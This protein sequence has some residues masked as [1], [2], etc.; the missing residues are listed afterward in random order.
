MI[1]TPNYYLWFDSYDMLKKTALQN[2]VKSL[3]TQKLSLP[4][5][6]IS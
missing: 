4:E 6:K 5:F 1:M 3:H 2:I